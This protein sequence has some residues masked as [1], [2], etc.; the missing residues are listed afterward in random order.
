[1]YFVLISMKRKG[2]TCMATSAEATDSSRISADQRSD[3]PPLKDLAL[4][5]S[6]VTTIFLAGGSFF[7]AVRTQSDIVTR[8]DRAETEMR[9]SQE[10]TARMDALSAKVEAGLSDATKNR[11]LNRC[12]DLSVQLAPAGKRSAGETRVGIIKAMETLKCGTF[13][14]GLNGNAGPAR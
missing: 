4:I 14:A 9:R 10:L 11:L 3:W 7:V 5:G 13:I 2:A 8:L 1:M 6:A 12:I